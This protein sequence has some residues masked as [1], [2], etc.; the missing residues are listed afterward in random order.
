MDRVKYPHSAPQPT[1][2]NTVE[3]PHSSPRSIV[4]PNEPRDD[5]AST[6]QVAPPEGAPLDS[7]A[8]DSA[9]GQAARR[10]TKAVNPDSIIR[11]EL[12]SGP[13]GTPHHP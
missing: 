9:L 3:L 2:P 6:Q 12:E 4:S 8:N 1:Y 11:K 7:H 13:G 5:I 10:N